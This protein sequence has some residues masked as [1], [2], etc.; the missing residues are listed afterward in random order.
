MK[1]P[2]RILF[3]IAVVFLVIVA[4]ATR[5]AT[6]QDYVRP[7]PRPSAVRDW[8]LDS[9]SRT[10]PYPVG[11]LVNGVLLGSTAHMPKSMIEDF[12]RAGLSHVTAVSGY[13]ISIIAVMLM[14]IL[15]ERVGRRRAFWLVLAILWFFM[16]ITG[17]QASV[18]RA[19]IMGVLALFAQRLGRMPTP[20]HALTIA[21]AVMVAINPLILRFDVGFQLSVLATLGIL[22][23]VPKFERAF[24][25][26]RALGV[27]GETAITTLSAQIFVLPLIL[28]YFKTFSVVFLPA[29][30]LIL[31]LIPLFML[32][33]FLAGVLGWIPLAGSA[34]GLVAWSL[35]KLILFIVHLFASLPWATISL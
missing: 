28:Y 14:G 4:F 17:L 27:F 29:N 23:F 15:S 32:L 18:I 24:P 1:Y 9:V 13:N 12:R 6:R 35:G 11:A 19:T 22:V 5:N 30:I 16:V 7:S 21:A 26:L 10:V 3:W 8:F 20:L 33:G 25:R 34:A 31:P 2:S